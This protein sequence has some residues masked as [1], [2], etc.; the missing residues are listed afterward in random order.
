MMKNQNFSTTLLVKATPKQV[1]EAINNVRGWWS[2]N[3]HG[4]T[5]QLQSEF[6]Y[7]FQDVHRCKMKITTLI[8]A[9]KIVWHVLDNH[10]NFTK[11]KQE[12][13]GSD[14]IFNISEK[15]GN[16]LLEFTHRGLSP[17]DECYQICHESWTNYIQHSLKNLILTGTGDPTP[18]EALE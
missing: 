16:T 2:E 18:A 1:F 6:S 9:Q 4:Q 5:D 7:H 13:I 17:A 11:A 15:E 14:I 8:P 12:W 10:F 3:I